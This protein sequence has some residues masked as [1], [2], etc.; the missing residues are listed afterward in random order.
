MRQMRILLAELIGTYILMLGGPGVAVLAAIPGSF[1]DVGVLAVALGFGFALLIIAYAVGP[2]SGGHVN[3]AVTLGFVLLRKVE[4]RAVPSYLIGQTIGAVL[5]GLTIWSIAH[6][7]SDASALGQSW[8]GVTDSNFATNLWTEQFMGFW[9]MVIA[10]IILTGVLVFVVL[11]TTS[12]SYASPAS[13][14]LHV[15]VT[16]TLIHLISIPIDNT[17]V[18]PVRSFGMAVFAGG[19]SFEQLWAF[20]VFPLLGAV[21]GAAAWVALTDEWS[22]EDLQAEQRSGRDAAARATAKI[23]EALDS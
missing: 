6:N 12:R 5:G 21:A 8:N 22:G 2:V 20:I 15:G 4:P 18:N 19:D 3:P 23:Q 9:P 11:S 17:S 7:A 1:G 10:E 13:V 14:G 16:L